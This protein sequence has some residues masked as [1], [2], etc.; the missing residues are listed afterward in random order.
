LTFFHN[1]GYRSA[2]YFALHLAIF[3]AFYRP[4]GAV[5]RRRNDA[6]DN[7]FDETLALWVTCSD[8]VGQRRFQSGAGDPVPLNV[9]TLNF[10][11]IDIEYKGQN[12]D[13]RVIGQA[14]GVTHLIEG[15]VRKDGNQVR[16]TAQLIRSDDGTHLWTESYDRE[17]KGV[18]AVQEEIATAIAA[19]LRVP[20]GL[21]AGESLV[22]NRTSDT[23]SYQDYL[24]A[25]ALVRG[26]GALEPGGPL[27]EAARL[28]EQV[29]ARDPNYAPA[30]ALL[31][32]AYS[33]TPIYTAAFFNGSIDDL[34][35]V[36][37]D[38]MQ[39]AEAA[40]QQATRLDP[41]SIDGYIALGYA[42]SA[43]G[44]FIQA[45]NLY[46]RALALDPGN[47]DAIHRFGLMLAT[48]GHLK[49]SLPLRLRLQAQ[50]PFVPTFNVATGMV[51]WESG[52]NDDA[53]TTYRAQLPSVFSR[54]YLAQVYASVGRY[55]EAADALREVPPGTFSAQTLT[56]AARLLRSA[57]GKSVPPRTAVSN[58][59]LGFVYA[60]TGASDRVLDFYERIAE[61]GYP[62][63]GDIDSLIWAPAYAPVRKTDRFK[64]YAR[65]AG[66]VEYWRAKGWP[67]LCHPTTGDDFECD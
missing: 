66:L 12:R 45:E 60:H 8:I 62:A 28:L 14:L 58:G 64:A 55:S 19:S 57:P 3:D 11:E 17:L 35:R 50:E 49:E 41:N 43:R 42:Q 1:L 25:K 2:A 38:A 7:N 32:Y 63:I 9:V 24:R 65:K 39:K 6:L 52:R 23:D 13:L 18:F 26:R 59:V 67:D 21:K 16:I 10:A 54:V 44:R 15:S 56:E 37:A 4:I 5:G 61:T 40:A 31:G 22:S 29:T 48:A 46:R 20:L 36:A 30:W 27:T 33:L 47:P 53:V 34:R 51:L